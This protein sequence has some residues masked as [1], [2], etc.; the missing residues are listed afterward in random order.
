[1]LDANGSY[2]YTLNNAN[3]AVQ[4]LNAGETTTDTFTYTITDADGDASSTTLTVTLTGTNDLVSVTVP[5]VNAEA[6]DLSVR[7][8]Q[9]TTG[10]FTI[11]APDG[12]DP[13]A[14]VTIAGTAISKAALEGSGTSNVTITT[15]QG[16]LTVTGYDPLT[17]IVGPAG[18]GKTTTR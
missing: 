7:E 4:A 3:P 17:V 8:D 16:V 10:S 12:L 5:D 18:A 13:V 9:T 14:A 2:T 6:G 11:S 1:M 15:P